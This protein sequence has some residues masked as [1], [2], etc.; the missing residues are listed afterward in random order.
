M[1]MASHTWRLAQPPNI[2]IF[3]VNFSLDL[4]VR[5]VIGLARW[6]ALFPAAVSLHVLVPRSSPGFRAPVPRRVSGC[7]FRH[8]FFLLLGFQLL[9][10]G[11][12][13]LNSYFWV[14]VFMFCIF[15]LWCSMLIVERP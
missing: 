13:V 6:L 9:G 8:G 15:I 2:F 3:F 11:F 5:W 7:N 10:F 1:A 4:S 14:L 12:R